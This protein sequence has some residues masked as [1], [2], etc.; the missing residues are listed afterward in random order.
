MAAISSELVEKHVLRLQ[1][2]K[3]C[4]EW[5]KCQRLPFS[6]T[7][8]PTAAAL[9][10]THTRKQQLTSAGRASCVA[11]VFGKPESRGCEV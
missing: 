8:L 10:N 3:T 1:A 5:L 7:F 2:E 9:C 4:S 6:L 11:Y